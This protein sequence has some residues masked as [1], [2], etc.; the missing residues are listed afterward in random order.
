MFNIMVETGIEG[1]LTEAAEKLLIISRKDA[2]KT[3]AD[4]IRLNSRILFTEN[5]PLCFGWIDPRVGII[6]LISEFEV[7]N[8]TSR[9]DFNKLKEAMTQYRI[10]NEYCSN[11]A[12]KLG[13]SLNYGHKFKLSGES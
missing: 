9:K 12:T 1:I 5:R 10:L 4:V 6:C 13:Y 7:K 2:K 3:E 11:N 8:Y